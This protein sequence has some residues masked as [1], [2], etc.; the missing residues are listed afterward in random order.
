[1]MKENF[2]RYGKVHAIEISNNSFWTH[3]DKPIVD[4]LSNST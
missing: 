3:L 4:A 2:A 1:M